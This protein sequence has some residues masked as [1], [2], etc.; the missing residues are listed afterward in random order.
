MFRPEEQCDWGEHS[1]ATCSSTGGVLCCGRERFLFVSLCGDTLVQA[2]RSHIG[3]SPPWGLPQ[4]LSTLR[5]LPI[6]QAER[7]DD[8]NGSRCHNHSADVEDV[9]V[10]ARLV[11]QSSYNSKIIRIIAFSLLHIIFHSWWDQT[12]PEPAKSDAE[13]G[14][15]WRQRFK[16]VQRT[17]NQIWIWG[18]LV[19]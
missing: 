17:L 8:E 3:F 11:N 9:E 12:G 13:N 16:K 7:H 5:W 4:S 10:L 19:D 2:V 1:V 14:S 15:V 6:Q 18:F